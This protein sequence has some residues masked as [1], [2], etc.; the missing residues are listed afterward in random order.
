MSSNTCNFATST[1]GVS[2]GPLPQVKLEL[3]K[4]EIQLSGEKPLKE[5]LQIF[6]CFYL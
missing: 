3:E 4:L 2:I 5:V 1:V 6:F